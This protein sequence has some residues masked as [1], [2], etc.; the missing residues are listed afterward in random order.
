MEN[1]PR[2]LVL[3]ECLRRPR[4]FFEEKGFL[5]VMTSKNLLLVKSFCGGL[6]KKE[7]GFLEKIPLAAGGIE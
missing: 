1:H 3:K 4:T 2:P 5:F 6:D 7:G